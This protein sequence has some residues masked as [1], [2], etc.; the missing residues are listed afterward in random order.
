MKNAGL[1]VVFFYIKFGALK[2]F[3]FKCD[4]I[5]MF[6]SGFKIYIKYDWLVILIWVNLVEFPV[7]ESSVI[8]SV[9][10]MK[11]LVTFIEDKN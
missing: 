8:S 11:K 2:V 9:H 5:N 6:F 3:F 1:Y 10:E 4:R 7:H